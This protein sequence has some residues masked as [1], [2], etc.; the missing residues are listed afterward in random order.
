VKGE[1]TVSKIEHKGKRE[2]VLPRI[3]ISTDDARRLSALADSSMV[4]FPREAHFLARETERAKVVEDEADL[5]GVVRMGSQVRYCDD[6]TGD[7]RDVVL[8]YPHAADIGLK[9]IS[10]LTPVGAA[11]IGLS[12][13][14]A[15]EFQTP[16]RNTRS[17]TVLG[18]SNEEV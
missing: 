14:Q 2:P 7:V 1:I 8:V 10:V 13:G 16:G 17:L 15:I 9:R 3:V 11:L 6:K 4:L 5:R 12:V 18:V